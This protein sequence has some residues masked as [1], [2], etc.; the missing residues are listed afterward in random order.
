MTYTVLTPSCE[1][2][3]GKRR[4][5]CCQHCLDGDS[6]EKLTRVTE[7]LIGLLIYHKSTLCLTVCYTEIEF[8]HPC[9]VYTGHGGNSGLKTYRVF[10]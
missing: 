2:F 6:T 7:E 9:I 5:N 3:L 4:T 1:Q 8:P 10:F